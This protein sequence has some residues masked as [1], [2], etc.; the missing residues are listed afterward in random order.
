VAALAS[1]GSAEQGLGGDGGAEEGRL[2]QEVPASSR[3]KRSVGEGG[4]V[5]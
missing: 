5:A 2:A 3:G 4:W 1:S